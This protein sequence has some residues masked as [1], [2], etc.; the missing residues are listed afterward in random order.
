MDFKNG[1]MNI[2]AAG[3]NGARTVQCITLCFCLHNLEFSMTHFICNLL[4]N[5]EGTCST[6]YEY[7]VCDVSKIIILSVWLMGR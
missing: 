1:V 7:Y 5:L 3:Y 4:F 2:Q 6:K